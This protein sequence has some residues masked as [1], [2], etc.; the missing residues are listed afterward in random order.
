VFFCPSSGAFHC[1]HSNGICHTG[2]LTVPSWS[3]SQAVSKPLWH[4]PLLCVQWKTPDNGQKNCPK[5]VEFYSKNECEKLAHLVGFIM[6][7]YN[8]ARS[9]VRQIWF[10]SIWIHKHHLW[11]AHDAR[12]QKPKT[13]YDI[14]AIFNLELP[15][16]PYQ[17]GSII[18]IVAPCTS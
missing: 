18:I 3:C 4:I 5:H 16:T 10:K 12:S 2:L 1:T 9:P 7:I 8:A 11:C 17:Y 14:F 15:Y 13:I 6:R